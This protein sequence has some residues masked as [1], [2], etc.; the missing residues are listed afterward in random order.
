MIEEAEGVN[1]PWV[2]VHVCIYECYLMSWFSRDLCFIGGEG[3]N[4]PGVYMHCAI[5]DMKF[6]W[7]YGFPE[8]YASIVGGWWG[9]SAIGICELYYIY[10]K[11]IMV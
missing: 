7:C 3:F 4:L 2:Y 11:L 5:Y 6:I 1:L 10:K 9:L 8:I